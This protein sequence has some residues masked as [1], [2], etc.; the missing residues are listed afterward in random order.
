MKDNVPY[1]DFFQDGVTKP[2]WKDFV[3]EQ[4]L[5]NVRAI[6]KQDSRAQTTD[7]EVISRWDSM[8]THV[9]LKQLA[10]RGLDPN[11]FE[12]MTVDEIHEE[13]SR[14]TE[15]AYIEAAN[16]VNPYK[17]KGRNND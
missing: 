14:N 16:P 1:Y 7:E 10:D 5:S 11:D 4:P 8:T 13:L 9:M 2:C 17:S 6:S 12:G 3:A 15:D